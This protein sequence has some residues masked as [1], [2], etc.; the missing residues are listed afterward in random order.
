MTTPKP[1]TYAAAGV[2]INQGATLV[3]RIKPFAKATARPGADAA[4]GGFGAA[5][6]LKAA[7]FRDPILIAATDGVGTKLEIAQSTGQLR[8]I[9]QDL[10][11]MCVNDALAQGAEPL[12]FL[13]YFATGRLEVDQAATVIEGVALAC[14][15]AGCA[16]A[17]GETA[18]MPGFY[19]PG[20]FDLAGFVLAAAERGAL[21]PRD[22]VAAGDVV[23]GLASSG[24]HA[25]GYS[26]IRRLVDD[27]GFDYAAPAP[28]DPQRSLASALLEPTK[29]YVQAALPILRSGRVKAAAHITGGGLPENLPRV[30]PNGL[31]ADID[32]EAWARPP[33]FSWLQDLGRVGASE[34]LR[35]FNCGIGLALIMAP[36]DAAT[37]RADLEAAGE[38]VFD[39]GRIRGA[40]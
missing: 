27:H 9:G 18:E 16:L 29:I 19:A 10:V 34:M 7:G 2:D 32:P 13:D 30:L 17:G 20:Q 15:E 11:A 37:V 35:T 25:N 22:D 5:F 3:E 23:L 26:L 6:D 24:P 36:D 14:R 8:T 12:L 40:T 38:T 21:L 4:L 39:I 28:F 31:S 33:V 1:Y